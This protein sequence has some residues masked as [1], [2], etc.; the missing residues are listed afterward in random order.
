MVGKSSTKTI[1]EILGKKTLERKKN[2]KGDNLV[3]EQ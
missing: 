1:K 2:L 3:R